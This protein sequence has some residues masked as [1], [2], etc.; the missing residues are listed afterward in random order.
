[1]ALT[2]EDKLKG[3]Y[4]SIE[5]VDI[6]SCSSRLIYIKGYE[7]P[8]KVTKQVFKDGDDDESPYL[9]LVTNDIDLTSEKILEIYKRGEKANL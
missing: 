9:Y 2:L 5:D 3:N 1:M 8:L 6:G 4:V 7:N